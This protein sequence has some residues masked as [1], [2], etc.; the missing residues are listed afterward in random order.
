LRLDEIPGA[1]QDVLQV[2]KLKQSLLFI[3]PV[4]Y[5]S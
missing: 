4:G 1:N 3:F 2:L 5:R